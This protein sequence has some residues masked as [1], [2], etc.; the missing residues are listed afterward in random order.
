MR[1]QSSRARRTLTALLA[2]GVVVGAAAL[3][4][5]APANA[6]PVQAPAP[7]PVADPATPKDAPTG[8]LGSHDAELLAKAET[9]GARN[10]TL[11]ISTDS[12]EASDVAAEIKKL[13]GTIAQ[14]YDKVGYVLAS[15][16]T[17]KVVKAAKLPGVSAVDLDEAIQLPDPEAARGAKAAAQGK[18]GI[19]SST[20]TGALSIGTMICRMGRCDSMLTSR[21]PCP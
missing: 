11:I 21:G 9:S 1:Q 2:S 7:A 8:E 5:P 4:G 10:V 6:A 14:R 18:T 20:T 3:S 12:G 19:R 17:A 16:P 13:G 15:V